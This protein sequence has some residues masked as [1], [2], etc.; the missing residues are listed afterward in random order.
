MFID[1]ISQLLISHIWPVRQSFA[2][3]G[4]WV[5]DSVREWFRAIHSCVRHIDR[6]SSMVKNILV[7][8]KWAARTSERSPT[9]VNFEICFDDLMIETLYICS[10]LA[11]K[12]CSQGVN[13]YNKEEKHSTSFDYWTLLEIDLQSH[14]QIFKGGCHW[15]PRMHSQNLRRSSDGSASWSRRRE[16]SRP[17][18]PARVVEDSRAETSGWP[19]L[20]QWRCKTRD[21]GFVVWQI[22][23]P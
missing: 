15:V 16:A 20:R 5:N 12:T 14:S 8:W 4:H 7:A 3:K 13:A 23:L 10:D 18:S 19:P 9:W 11:T 22:R 1:S 17:S 2:G 21:P 6:S